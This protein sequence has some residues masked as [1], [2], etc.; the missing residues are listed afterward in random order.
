MLK[1]MFIQSTALVQRGMLDE[2][3]QI[4]VLVLLPGLHRWVE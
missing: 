4:L 2:V 3:I 1:K